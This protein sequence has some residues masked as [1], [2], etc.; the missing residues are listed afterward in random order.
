MVQ[1]MRV[2][3]ISRVLGLCLLGMCLQSGGSVWA[4]EDA[5][6]S[7]PKVTLRAADKT[8]SIADLK[9]RVVIV[10]FWA[11]WCGPC[12]QSFPWMNAMQ[13]KYQDQG[14]EIVAVNLDQK[15]EEAELF[16]KEI[17]A[18]FTVAFDAAGVS[19][20]AFGVMGMPSSYLIDR[21]GNIRSEHIGFHPD[22]AE[23]YESEIAELL[24]H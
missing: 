12:R 23:A 9:G 19:P 5:L 22:E 4:A 14:L 8:F 18:Q 13:Q 16:L 17:P 24:K 15:P 21:Q 7:V 1:F 6:R 2:E 20:E 10:D 3:K 11:S